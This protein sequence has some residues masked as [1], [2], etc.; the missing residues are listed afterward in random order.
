MEIIELGQQQYGDLIKKGLV[1]VDFYAEWCGPCKVLE[2]VLKQLGA[3]V[4]GLQIIKVNIEENAELVQELGIMSVPTLIL[5]QNGI[6][7]SVKHGF[8][9]LPVLLEWLSELKLL[10]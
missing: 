7:Q 1:L 9:P 6:L 10:P 3:E 4:N 8:S 2:P 5:Y